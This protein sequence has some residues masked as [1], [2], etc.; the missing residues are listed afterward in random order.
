M[1][2]EHEAKEFKEEFCSL[3]CPQICG[4]VAK[5]VIELI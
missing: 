3:N 5:W 2:N 1:W 4:N